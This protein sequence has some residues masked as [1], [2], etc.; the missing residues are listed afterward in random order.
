[1]QLLAARLRVISGTPSAST[2][3]SSCRRQRPQSQRPVK[4]EPDPHISGA[5]P[6]QNGEACDVY[7]HAG[8]FR[9]GCGY[10]TAT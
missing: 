7:F 4:H 3:S 8:G 10:N 2:S 5:R 6:G 9:G 1:M